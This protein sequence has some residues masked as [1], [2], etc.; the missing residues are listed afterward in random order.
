MEWVNYQHLL[1]FWVVAREGGLVAA[2]KVL[3]LSHPT[4][5]AQVHALEDHLGEK[6]FTKV[7]RRLVL[8]DVGRVVAR[9]A[10]EIFTLGREMVDTVKGRSTGQPVRLSVGIVDVVPKLVVKRLL[11]PALALEEPVKIFCHEGS[12]DKLLADLALHSIDLLIADAPLPSG[13]SVRAFN[14]VLGESGVTFFGT[15][16][17]VKA[18]QAGFPQSLEGAPMLLPL[19]NTTLRRALN[20]W[21]DRLGIRP[22]VVAE[23]EDSALLKEFGADGVGIFAGSSVVAKELERQYRVS[24]LGSAP[25]IRERF[26]A[27]SVERRLKNPAV[28]AI[29]DAARED[30]F[31]LE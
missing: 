17:L 10:D 26:Y 5:S 28:V 16:S 8:T 31:A 24:A 11:E 18:L 27:V 29:S 23:F 3:H 1:Y 14:H 2:G 15:R 13:S 7:G 6:L 19:E 20:Q 4:L 9:Y 22:R 30:L 12:Y 25:E 21:F